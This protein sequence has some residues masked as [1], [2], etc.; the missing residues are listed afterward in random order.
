MTGTFLC[1]LTKFPT[2]LHRW[3]YNTTSFWHESG[4]VKDDTGF[5]PLINTTPV[6]RILS[7]INIH[8]TETRKTNKKKITPTRPRPKVLKLSAS[9]Q[10]NAQASDWYRSYVQFK[11]DQ[12]NTWQWNQTQILQ[13]N[14]L[15]KFVLHW[16]SSELRWK[17]LFHCLCQEVT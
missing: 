17:S 1:V 16:E 5:T 14:S 11:H 10:D 3:A 12:S 6:L 7:N 9:E 15:S 8:R 4:S 13:F 2:T